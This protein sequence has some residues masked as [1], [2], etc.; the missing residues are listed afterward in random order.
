MRLLK[1]KNMVSEE[2]SLDWLNARVQYLKKD[3]W[4]W[5]HYNGNDQ[6]LSTES[7]N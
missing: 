6:N 3:H 2:I 4:A 7:K 5:R 1:L